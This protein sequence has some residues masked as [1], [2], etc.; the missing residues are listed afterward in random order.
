MGEGS[1]GGL[2]TTDTASAGNDILLLDV[3]VDQVRVLGVDET[4]LC[5]AEQL[6]EPCP[7]GDQG[8][9]AGSVD[10]G[11]LEDSAVLDECILSEGVGI[12]LQTLSL[13]RGV[14]L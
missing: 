8:V 1:P 4:L 3:S 11:I 14:A 10:S 2:D 6:D 9:L 7:V 13:E 5:T 12:S